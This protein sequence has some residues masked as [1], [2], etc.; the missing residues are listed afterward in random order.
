MLRGL[1][2]QVELVR[3]T[4]RDGLWLEGAWFEPRGATSLPIDGCLFLHGTG[5]N[6]SAPGVLEAFATRVAARGVAAL[7]INTRGHD[8]IAT[9]HGPKRSIRGGATYEEVADCPHDVRAGVDFLTERGCRRIALVGHS[10]GGVKSAYTLAHEQFAV[11]ARLIVISSPRFCHARF[12]ASPRAD[13]FRADFA[14]AQAAVAAGDPEHLMPVTQ[15][16]P[17]LATARGFLD[18]YGADDRY[19]L[20]RHLPKSG[21][22]TLVIIGTRSPEQSIGFEGLPET[23]Q[24]LAAAHP[25]IRV[26]LVEGANTNYTGCTEVPFER[27]MRWLEEP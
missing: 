2:M 23:L 15:P 4:T 14:A 25:H 18:K 21:C 5:S 27:A 7:R 19:D 12:M 1:A 16:M 17:F 13:A 9:I 11:V 26:E 22:P 3:L 10:M 8:G 20:L 6:F 24:E